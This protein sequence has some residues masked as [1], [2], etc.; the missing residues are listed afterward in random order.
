[1]CARCFYYQKTDLPPSHPSLAP[2]LFFQ[3]YDSP[4]HDTIEDTHATYDG[5]VEMCLQAMARGEKVEVLIASHNQTSI[6]KALSEM[7]RL[8]L[9]GQT[10]GVYFGQLLGMYGNIWQG[11]REGGRE[12]GRLGDDR[13]R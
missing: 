8:N 12:G 5:C 4:I 10:T 11:R 6:E 1:V 7:D 2:S 3:G 13:W 9:E